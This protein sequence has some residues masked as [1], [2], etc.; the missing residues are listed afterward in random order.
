MYQSHNTVVVEF[1]VL[2]ADSESSQ[3][4]QLERQ[5]PVQLCSPADK[6]PNHDFQFD[7]EQ[8]LDLEAK[9]D[10]EAH[11]LKTTED[12]KFVEG[13][14]KIESIN[15]ETNSYGQLYRDIEAFYATV[16]KRPATS[17]AS[18]PPAKEKV[19]PNDPCPCQSGAKYKKCHG[20]NL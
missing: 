14:A 13:M 20:K 7:M 2:S 19:R 4:P 5:I 11:R 17:T 10:D 6:S 8:K 15:Q 16:Q 12:E 18:A 9:L 3:Q 1:V